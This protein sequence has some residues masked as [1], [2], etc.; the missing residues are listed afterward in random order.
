MS[1][2]TVAQVLAA[3][4][5]RIQDQDRAART[6]ADRAVDLRRAMTDEQ[7]GQV[8]AALN[9]A[10]LTTAQRAD[11]IHTAL[12]ARAATYDYLH[13]VIAAALVLGLTV[14]PEGEPNP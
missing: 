4:Y 13:S 14:Q 6:L 12:V 5:R 10:T 3:T 9:D 1:T 7:I 8:R 2:P 11:A